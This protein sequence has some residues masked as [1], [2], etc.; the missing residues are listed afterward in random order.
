M[1]RKSRKSREEWKIYKN[2]FDQFTTRKLFELTSQGHIG[3]LEQPIALGKEANIFIAHNKENVP[4]IV[5]IYRLE[6]CNFN[7]M[8]SYISVDPRFI[9]LENQKRKIIFS[10]VQREYRNLMIAREKIKVPKPILFRDNIL[11]MEMIGE[12]EPAQQL[13][14]LPPENPDEFAKKIIKNIELLLKAELVHGDLSDFNILNLNEEPIF[15][16]FSQATPIGTNGAREMLE[17]DIKNAL[18]CFKRTLKLDLNKI[19]EK[20][21]KKYDELASDKL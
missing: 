9:G 13:K 10:W 3:D 12:E 2:V 5:K 18:N 4:V 17:R 21:L 1:V 15:I 8:H 20:L 7:K 14:N 11:L 6:N 19:T 16:D